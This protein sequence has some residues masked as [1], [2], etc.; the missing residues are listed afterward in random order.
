M[1]QLYA[2]TNCEVSLS[3]NVVTIRDNHPVNPSVNEVL[4]YLTDKL[5]DQICAELE[6]EL[7]KLQNKQ[8]WLTL[9]QIFIE[10][11]VYKRIE[12]ATSESQVISE[13]YEG[14]KPF[15]K[16]FVRALTDEDIDKLLEIRI[17]RISK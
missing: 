11:R 3:S 5:R 14:M 9:E 4:R 13:V 8:H 15:S 6:L 2:Y 16:Y 1:P 17:R 7:K 12:D 10:K